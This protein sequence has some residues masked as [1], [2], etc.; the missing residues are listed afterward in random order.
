MEHSWYFFFLANGACLWKLLHVIA[1]SQAGITAP[2]LIV[3]QGFKAKKDCSMHILPWSCVYTPLSSIPCIRTSGANWTRVRWLVTERCNHHTTLLATIRWQNVIFKPN[4][5]KRQ[6]LHSQGKK[7]PQMFHSP[8]HF[9][10]TNQI[11][12]DFD[13]I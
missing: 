11:L 5:W 7:I 3:M 2:T 13:S 9:E 8:S 4:V 12:K 1:I 10:K 6:W